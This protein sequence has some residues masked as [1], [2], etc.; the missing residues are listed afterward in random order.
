MDRPAR[1]TRRRSLAATGAALVALVALAIGLTW[2]SWGDPPQWKPDGL[3]YQVQLLELRGVDHADALRDVFAG[4]LAAPRVLEERT[5]PE[6]VPRLTDPQWVEYSAQFYRR[7]WVL[8]ALGAAIEP[9]FG[10]DSLQIVSL[11]GFVLVGPL[12][13]LLLRLRFSLLPSLAAAAVCVALPPLRYWAEQPLS[14]SLAVAVEALAFVC[15]VLALERGAW[16]L[17]PWFATMLALGFTRDTTAVLVAGAAWLALRLRT[18]RSL[19]ILVLG[20]LAALPPPL[21]FG[22][23]LREALAYMFSD[24]TV[25]ADTSWGFILENYPKG[26]RR[27]QIHDFQYFRD[28][29]LA[30]L[31]GIGGL[32]AVY[33][34]RR[35]ADPY[36]MLVRGAGIAGIAY[37]LLQPNYTALRLELVFV[38]VIAVGLALVVDAVQGRVRDLPA[39][40]AARP[41]AGKR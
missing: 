19:V 13:F 31:A 40:V 30:A 28:H 29:P 21:F 9:A 23:P 11:V 2:S 10:T 14:D 34:F 38:P 3:Y 26:L 25:P 12:L 1:A 22:A 33:V 36:F 8:P 32:L 16:W 27:V 24:F 41:S 20:V 37:L 35:P 17:A 7:R 18:T 5:N 6:A 39:S 15:A 4:P